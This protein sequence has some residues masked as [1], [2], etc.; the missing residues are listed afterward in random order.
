MGGE[1]N[2]AT[3]L[4]IKLESSYNKSATANFPSASPSPVP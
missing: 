4:K 1:P 3:S 2:S